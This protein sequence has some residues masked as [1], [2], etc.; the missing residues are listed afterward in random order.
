MLTVTIHGALSSVWSC[1][2]PTT[3]EVSGNSFISVP[4]ISSCSEAFDSFG[5]ATSPDDTCIGCASLFGMTSETF[6]EETATD[7]YT[8]FLQRLSNF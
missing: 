2:L 7:K 6:F 8:C 4:K 1:L 3:S 5:L